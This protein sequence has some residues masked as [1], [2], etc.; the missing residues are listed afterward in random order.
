[1]IVGADQ[2]SDAGILHASARL[3]GSYHLRRVYYSAFSPIPDSSTALP[4]QQAAADARAPA[5]P[6]RLADALLRLRAAEILAGEPDGM[7]DLDIDPK[8]AWA[9]R[10]R[11]AF[12]VDVNRADREA[13]LR[14]PGLGTKVVDA[15]PGDPPPP[16]AAAG[17]RRPAL[18]VDRQG[19][20]L[21]RRRRLVAGRLTDRAGLR[22]TLVPP[23]SNCRLF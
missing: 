11:G 4:L 18:P 17:G 8:L 13:L 5:L 3:Y 1:M 12:P 19:Q 15:D 10:N 9:L 6:G 23:A 22:D 7:L 21:H 2:T 16:P 20:A 14:V